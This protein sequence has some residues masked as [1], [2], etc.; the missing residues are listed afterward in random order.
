MQHNTRQIAR[1]NARNY[2]PTRKSVSSFFFLLRLVT[3]LCHLRALVPRSVHASLS[4]FAYNSCPGM[5]ETE[6][7]GAPILFY[8][9]DIV[10]ATRRMPGNEVGSSASGGKEG[11]AGVSRKFDENWGE[12]SLISVD[13]PEAFVKISIN[14]F[15]KC[16]LET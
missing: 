15:K 5:S 3:E 6:R 13:A 14:I 9:N 10:V 2:R 11:G 16:H 8:E 12:I 1:T 4:L 7:C